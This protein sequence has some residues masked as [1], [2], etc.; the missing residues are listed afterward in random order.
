MCPMEWEYLRLDN[1]CG[2][3]YERPSPPRTPTPQCLG[4][5]VRIVKVKPGSCS[6]ETMSVC[7]VRWEPLHSIHFCEGLLKSSKERL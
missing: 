4:L 6:I 3:E 5:R 2:K 1:R 7:V